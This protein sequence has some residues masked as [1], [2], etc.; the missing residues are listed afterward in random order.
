MDGVNL[1]RMRSAEQSFIQSG[2]QAPNIFEEEF[3]GKFNGRRFN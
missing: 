1:C 2:I 3:S